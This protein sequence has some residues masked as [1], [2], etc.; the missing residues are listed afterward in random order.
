MELLKSCATR[1][2]QTLIVVTHNP[3]IAQQAQVV[4]MLEDGRIVAN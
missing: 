4:V 3:E 2:G 1:F